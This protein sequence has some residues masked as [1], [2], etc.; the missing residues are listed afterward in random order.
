MN[1]EVA[2]ERAQSSK[3]LIPRTRLV[4]T[5]F[6]DHAQKIQN[7]VKGKIAEGQARDGAAA[8]GRN[9]NEKQLN[10]VPIAPDRTGTEPFL[11]LEVVFEKSEHDLA[12]GAAH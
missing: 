4:P 10:R 2:I 1:G 5:L 7:A 9:M 3:P 12:E 11:D 6:L 8:Q